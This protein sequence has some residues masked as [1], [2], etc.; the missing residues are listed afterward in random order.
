MQKTSAKVSPIFRE[1]KEKGCST[2]SVLKDAFCRSSAAFSAAAAEQKNCGSLAK[3]LYK[4]CKKLYNDKLAERP[5]R[6][7]ELGK[8]NIAQKSAVIKNIFNQR[9]KT[10]ERVEFFGQNQKSVQTA[11]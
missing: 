5:A 3:K 2:P 8:Q 6:Q 9:E 11:L 10:N 1:Y 4:Q 7:Q